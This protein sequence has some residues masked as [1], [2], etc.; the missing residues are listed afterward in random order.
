[1]PLGRE[2]RAV[3][4]AGRER[5]EAG[6]E[7]AGREHAERGKRR[8]ERLGTE[9]RRSGR[10]QRDGQRIETFEGGVS[11]AG[12]LFAVVEREYA[13]GSGHVD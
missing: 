10:E 7:H 3:V 9:R 6:Q 2:D 8:C 11:F 1:M 13:Y 12:N 4:V 5:S